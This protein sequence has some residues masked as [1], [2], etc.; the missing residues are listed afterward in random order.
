MAVSYKRLK[1]R[2]IGE[3]FPTRAEIHERL[4]KVRALAIFA[5]DPISSNAY[6]TEAIMAVLLVLGTSVENRLTFPIALAVAVLILLVITS[7][8][9]TILH[10]PDGGGAYTVAKDN[11]GTM[12]SLFAASALLIDY[13]LTVSVS[14]SAGIR[15]V[16]SALPALFPY[17]VWLALLAILILTWVNLRG[18]RESGTIFALPTYAFVTGVL[19]VVVIGIVRLTGFMGVSAPP[20]IIRETLSEASPVAQFAFLWLV[21]RAFAAGCT[22]LTGIEAISNGVQAFKPPESK[23]AAKTMVAMGIIAMSL[24]IGISYVATHLG[25]IPTESESVLSQMTRTVMSGIPGNRLVYGWVQFFTMMILILAAN[26]GY[27]DFPRLSSFLAKDGFLPRWMQNRGDRLVY[28]FGIVLLAVFA[29]IIVL[30]FRADEIAMLPLYALGVMLS[31]SLSQTGMFLLMGKVG[32]LAPGETQKTSVTTIH[33]ERFVT[34][35]RLLNLVG[36]VVTF[37]VLWILIATKFLEGAWL[38]VIAIP[39]IVIMFRAIKK[40][41]RSVA[42]SLTTE[43]YTDGDLRDIADVVVIPVA[44]IHRGTLRSLRYAKRLSQDVRAV[45]II[46]SEAMRQRIEERWSMFPGSTAS[47]KL[48]LIDYEYRDI[49]TPLVDYIQRISEEEFPG[50]LT[51]VVIPEFV[52]ETLWGQ[53]LHN[54]TAA[55]LRQRL[56]SQDGIVIIDV[57]YL[58]K[59]R[60][61]DDSDGAG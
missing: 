1:R 51:T 42:Q 28:D 2:F 14:V 24:F 27:Q 21:L 56:R 61:A 33:Y 44:D 32:K 48:V 60:D 50:M 40:H 58:V 7:Y 10:Y 35:K 55:L 20:P 36:A 47:V 5:S 26:T 37:I 59:A 43:G 9:Q 18:V 22:A 52:P 3:P 6:A 16:T 38:V 29:S 12:P 57:P 39:L 4:D 53:T 8:I 15:A 17:S 31:F 11:L 25:L 30:V 49:L 45:S 19:L 41:Y 23:N 13:V 46:T 34:G 54:Q